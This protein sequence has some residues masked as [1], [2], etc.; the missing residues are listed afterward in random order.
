[1]LMLTHLQVSALA[2]RG[3]GG[4]SPDSLRAAGTASCGVLTCIPLTFLSTLH[5]DISCVNA[6]S[7]P[8]LTL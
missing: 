5:V 8:L 1:M 7:S 2:G 6:C 3:R 4:D